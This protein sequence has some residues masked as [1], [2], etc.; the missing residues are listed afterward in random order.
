MQR[1][2]CRSWRFPSLPF[3]RS[4]RT[5]GSR[6]GLPPL[7][8]WSSTHG[9]SRRLTSACPIILFS[10]GQVLD[11]MHRIAKA[12]LSGYA[13]VPAQRLFCDPDPDWLLPATAPDRL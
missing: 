3:E 11:G 12:V 1:R 13:T 7:V 8:L 2:G 10:D 6:V 4:T 5:A 9:R